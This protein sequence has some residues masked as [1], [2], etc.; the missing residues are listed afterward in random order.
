MSEQA[1]LLE[2][3]QPAI[4]VLRLNRPQALNA[5]T[6]TMVE[7]ITATLSKLRQCATTRVLVLTGE[8]RG[9]C[10][11]M[12][13]AA[14]DNSV[15]DIG[16]IPAKVRTQ[17]AFSAMIK[18][19]RAL[20]QPVVAAV[21][22][23]AAGAGMALALAADIRIASS[24]SKFL[25]AAIKLG[26]TA[27]EC[28]ISYHLPRLIGASRAFE[29]MLTGRPISAEEA[30][31]TGLVSRLVEPDATLETA[32]E[33]ARAILGNSPHA[34]RETKKLMWQNLDANSLETA[35]ALEN[36]TQIIA[37]MTEDFTEAT[38]AF[39]QKRPPVFSG[40]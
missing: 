31:K 13:I 21:N 30:E 8:G 2:H 10:A 14:P 24:T 37:S 26:L 28:G 20:E 7:D 18:A 15:R 29:I 6:L 22:G 38:T 16:I 12:D 9:F 5:L 33:I 11:G 19:V 32:L 4:A 25:I 34:I 3:P 23:P 17:D 40:R 36:Q 27:G 35:V 1:V 39:V